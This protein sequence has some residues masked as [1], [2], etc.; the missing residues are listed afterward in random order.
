MLSKK[1]LRVRPNLDHP[2]LSRAVRGIGEIGKVS[3][4]RV[5]ADLGARTTPCSGATV[6][7]KSDFRLKTSTKKFRGECKSTT[8]VTLAIDL[9]WL[10]KISD[11]ARSDSSIPALTI[12]FVRPDGKPRHHLNPEWVMIPVWAFKE[13][14]EP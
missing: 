11:E 8:G 3:E 1:K 4:K 5:A 6:G 10:S 12:S 9:S 2:F 13:L 7:A 14:L